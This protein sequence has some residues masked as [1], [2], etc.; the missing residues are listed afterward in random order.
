MLKLILN[1]IKAPTWASRAG[2]PMFN[3]SRTQTWVSYQNRN[4]RSPKKRGY[5]TLVYWCDNKKLA[6]NNSIGLINMQ[7]HSKRK[8]TQFTQEQNCKL[9]KQATH[10]ARSKWLSPTFPGK[11]LHERSRLR[12]C[13]NKAFRVLNRTDNKHVWTTS[14]SQ[15]KLDKVHLPIACLGKNA[16]GPTIQKQ[17]TS[18]DKRSSRQQSAK[19]EQNKIE[20]QAYW[21]LSNELTK[22][23]HTTH[24][25]EDA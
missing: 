20:R 7:I 3:P 25:L 13:T 1:R 4:S 6:N 22:L 5:P 17:M 8:N 9:H 12:L 23:S 19:K 2:E 16:K 24:V 14:W 18:K 10:K 15:T 21:P 11:S